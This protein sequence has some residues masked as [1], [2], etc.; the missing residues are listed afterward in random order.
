MGYG[1]NDLLCGAALEARMV[2]RLER[3]AVGD[4]G[5]NRHGFYEQELGLL[6]ASMSQL[7]GQ[8]TAVDSNLKTVNGDHLQPTVIGCRLFNAR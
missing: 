8:N 7:G 5:V 1:A 2:S 4:F 6:I 3:Q